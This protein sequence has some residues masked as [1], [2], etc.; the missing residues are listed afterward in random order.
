MFKD[1][2]YTFAGKA[3]LVGAPYEEVEQ[4]REGNE[5]NVFRFP[6]KIIEGNYLPS[7]EIIEETDENQERRAIRKTKKKIVE[8]ANQK[9]ASNQNK[10]QYRT[11]KTKIYGRDPNIHEYVKNLAEGVC[12]LCEQDAPLK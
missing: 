4:D 11:V 5:R 6:L 8:I 2:E 3:E 12:Q 1:R 7:Q 10:S 9:S